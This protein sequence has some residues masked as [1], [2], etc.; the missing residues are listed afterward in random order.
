[1]KKGT[2]IPAEELERIMAQADISGD[3]TLDYE[4]RVCVGG[5]RWGV[6]FNIPNLA[7]IVG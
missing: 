5:E 7:T 3:G 4:V 2:N 1:M 6:V